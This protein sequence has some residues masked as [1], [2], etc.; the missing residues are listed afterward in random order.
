MY[1]YIKRTYKIYTTFIFNVANDCRW[2]RVPRVHFG[3][4]QLH[5]YTTTRTCLMFIIFDHT[6]ITLIA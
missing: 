4:T 5:Y 2:E 1:E 6:F 3:F